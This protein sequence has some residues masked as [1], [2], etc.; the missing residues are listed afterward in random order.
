[1]SGRIV[2]ICWIAIRVRRATATRNFWIVTLNVLSLGLTSAEIRKRVESRDLPAGSAPQEKPSFVLGELYA[3]VPQHRCSAR[4][5]CR[6]QLDA[7]FLDD[8]LSSI[9]GKKPDLLKSGR[10]RRCLWKER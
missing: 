4:P 9:S 8:D 6:A 5:A 3:L 10:L 1:M 7:T 2:N